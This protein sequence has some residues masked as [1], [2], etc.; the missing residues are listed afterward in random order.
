MEVDCVCKHVE[1]TL[2]V[3]I[4]DDLRVRLEG[5]CDGLPV[6]AESAGVSDDIAVVSSKVVRFDEGISTL[7]MLTFRQLMMAVRNE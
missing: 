6:R 2:I 3:G 1:H 7:E 4:E 5:R